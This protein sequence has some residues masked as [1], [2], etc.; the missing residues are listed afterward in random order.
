MKGKGLL[1]GWVFGGNLNCL[2]EKIKNITK[3]EYK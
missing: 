3:V 1:P 2:K